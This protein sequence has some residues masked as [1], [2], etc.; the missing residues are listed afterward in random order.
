MQCE[1]ELG[2]CPPCV[3]DVTCNMTCQQQYPPH[4]I[5]G[6][7]DLEDISGGAGTQNAQHGPWITKTVKMVKDLFNAEFLMTSSQLLMEMKHLFC[8]GLSWLKG[9]PTGTPTGLHNMLPTRQSHFLL[10]S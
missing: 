6:R 9:S 4:G 2:L 10:S 1:W 8:L 3:T 5:V 7:T